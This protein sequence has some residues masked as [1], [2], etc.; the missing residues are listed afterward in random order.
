MVERNSG[1]E[2]MLFS[3]KFKDFDFNKIQRFLEGTDFVKNFFKNQDF[4]LCI[5]NFYQKKE[6][7]LFVKDRDW[8]S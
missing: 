7:L 1:E 5:Y 6:I 2:D 8:T 4:D 3:P